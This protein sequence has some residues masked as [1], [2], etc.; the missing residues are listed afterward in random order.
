[1]RNKEPKCMICGDKTSLFLTELYDDRYGAPGKYSIYKCL[2]CGFGRL[3]PLLNKKIIS[4]FYSKYY[5]LGY[6]TVKSVM[7]SAKRSNKFLNWLNGTRHIAHYYVTVDSDVLDVGSGSGVSLLEIKNLGGRAFGVEP[8]PNAQKIAKKLGL[9]VHQGFLTDNIFPG[10]KFDYITASQVLEHDS[11][12]RSFLLAAGK[13]L[14]D[15]GQIVLSFPNLD[16]LYRKIFGRHWIHW[17]VPYHCNFFTRRAF[18]QLATSSG[19]KIKK[20]ITVTP[21]DWTIVQIAMFIKQPKE[22]RPSFIWSVIN[23]SKTKERYSIIKLF[24]KIIVFFALIPITFI[25]RLV[26]YFGRGESFLVIMEKGK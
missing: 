3:Y 13:H 4:K 19:L 2:N 10:R 26:D 1:M 18:I 5:P 17:H 7:S 6:E 11:D 12:F 20:L 16:A 23:S 21:N 24:Q 8:D 22:G 9:K 14:K 15:E 25:N